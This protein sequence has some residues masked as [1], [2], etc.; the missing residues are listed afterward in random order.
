[1]RLQLH[2]LRVFY[3]ITP[4][5]FPNMAERLLDSLCASVSVYA[6]SIFT[7]GNQKTLCPT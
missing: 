4:W 5:K 7:R 1:M 2:I 3:S 6:K